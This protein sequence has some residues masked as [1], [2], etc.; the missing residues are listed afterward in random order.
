MIKINEERLWETPL[1]NTNIGVD[2]EILDYLINNKD[3]IQ[4][5]NEDMSA[6]WVSKTDLDFPT[7]KRTIEDF[8]RS[9]FAMNITEIKFTNMWANILKKGEYH[10]LHSHNEHTMSGAY[11]LQTPV[12]SGQIYF[13]D[14]RPQTNSWTQ[15]FIDKGNMRFYTPKP[16]DLFMW[17]SFLEHGT[18][19]H[20]ADEERIMLSFDL[21]FNGPG[22]KFGHNGY[23]GE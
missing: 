23:N 11:Y 4:D 2:K 3:K 16:G 5:T 22:Y 10:L 1:F 9:L 17:P 15:K 20:G 21:R 6:A 14:P 8:S 13:K 19:P 18:T 7:L 12:N